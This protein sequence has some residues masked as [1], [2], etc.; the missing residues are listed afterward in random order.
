MSL[1]PRNYLRRV[2][3]IGASKRRCYGAVDGNSMDVIGTG[4]FYDFPSERYDDDGNQLLRRWLVTCEHLIRDA[5]TAGNS[6]ILIRLNYRC[7]LGTTVVSIPTHDGYWT[8]HSEVDVTV[9]DTSWTPKQPKQIDY[10][11]FRSGADSLTREECVKKGLYEG[12]EVFFVGF[13]TGWVPGQQDHPIV[14]SGVLAQIQGWIDEDHDTFLVD[15]SG[16]PGN[17]G[18]PVILKP[19]LMSFDNFGKVDAAFLIG[20]VA[21]RRFSEIKNTN[22]SESEKTYMEET[23]DLVEVVPVDAINETIER[24][25]AL[26]AN[27]P[28]E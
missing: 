21:E 24:A 9:T 5:K 18:G 23:A 16:F 26:E 11:K 10:G 13:P 8:K 25:M 2:A 7:G 27:D 3:A 4:F 20:M 28:D 6:S 22:L 15:G 17:S 12:D 19:Q 14:R 1:M